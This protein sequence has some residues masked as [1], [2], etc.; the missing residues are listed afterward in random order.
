MYCILMIQFT[1]QFTVVF[2][3]S[4]NTTGTSYIKC[5]IN[6]CKL[7]RHKNENAINN[8]VISKHTMSGSLK[9]PG[10][11]TPAKLPSFSP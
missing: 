1:K 4:L 8:I 11:A 9:Y 2:P 10:L 5:H 6:M 3:Q 7:Q